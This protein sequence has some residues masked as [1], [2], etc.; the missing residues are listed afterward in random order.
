M[1]HQYAEQS[2]P[3]LHVDFID[4]A[5]RIPEKFRHREFLYIEWIN[6]YMKEAGRFTWEKFK[7][8]PAPLLFNKYAYFIPRTI[9]AGFA[10]LFK[11]GI[12]PKYHMNPHQYWASHN[13]GL[14]NQIEGFINDNIHLVKKYH[15]LS[16]DI[17]DLT[18]QNSFILQGR[19]IT[20][21]AALKKYQDNTNDSI[22]K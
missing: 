16:N 19:I 7:V 20:L 3:F 4:F 11:Y 22:G 12:L 5:V 15:G 13:I 2:S 6:K 21:L 17:R 10:G 14:K 1:I 9:K 18:G 8:R